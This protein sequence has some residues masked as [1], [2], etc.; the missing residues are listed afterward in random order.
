MRFAYLTPRYWPVWLASSLL[1]LVIW[2]PAALQLRLGRLIGHLS[3]HIN[4]R[5]RHIARVNIAFCFPELSQVEQQHLLRASFVEFGIGVIES[6]I[7]WWAP[8]WRLP[9]R[10]TVKGLEYVE[11]AN[12]EGRGVVCVGAHYTSL[13]LAG[14]LVSQVVPAH[15]I[16]QPAKNALMDYF[17]LRARQRTFVSAIVRDEVR[18]AVKK[19]RAGE[20]VWIAPDID[21]RRAKH[22]VFVPFF[23]TLAA[24][25]T[26]ISIYA[27]LG[28][29][30]VIPF[31][32]HRLNNG[33]YLLEFMPPLENFPSEDTTDDA[34]R[35]NQVIE[36]GIKR[37]P[38]QYLWQYWRFKTRPDPN[39]KNPY[40]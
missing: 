16:Y 22:S 11:Q 8:N 6:A 7:A 24:T 29:A 30:V 9:K 15:V 19:L 26:V 32:H 5:K 38:A 33:E 28:D 23:N 39:D 18:T 3:Y 4:S 37:D 36:Q 17:M 14:R 25:T 27:D 1:W 20:V 40:K 12:A 13:S 31:Y 34:K 35:I 2:L 10:V 21:A